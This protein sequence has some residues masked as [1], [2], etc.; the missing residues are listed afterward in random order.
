MDRMTEDVINAIMFAALLS[1]G[2]W[3][4][5]LFFRRF[6]THTQARLHRTEVFNKLIEKFGS[7]KEFVDFVQTAE[8][9][10][11]LED[12]VAQP[13]NPL[14]KILRFLQAGILFI[15]IGG[16]YFLN[17]NRWKDLKEAQDPNYYHQM[18]DS[19]YWG[20]LATSLGVGLLVV[21]GVSYLFVRHWHLANGSAKQ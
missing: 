7:T 1:L 20:T 17:A 2:A 18:M 13:R 9:K 14:A 10:K 15:A 6:Q 5:W 12:P 4:V 16:A 8:G 11:L 21:A 19:N 3:I